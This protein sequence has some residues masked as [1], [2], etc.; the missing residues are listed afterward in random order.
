METEHDR[1]VAFERHCP[2]PLQQRNC[3][4]RLTVDQVRRAE[5]PE[6]HEQALG[7][8]HEPRG[9]CEGDGLC[10]VRHRLLELP[11]G[12]RVERLPPEYVR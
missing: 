1:H 3:A 10:S 6:E 5:A 8:G 4:G 12:R 7:A 2:A 9:L 11:E